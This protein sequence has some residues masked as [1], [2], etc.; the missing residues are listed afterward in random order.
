M[1]IEVVT[2]IAAEK[3]GRRCFM[4]E[5]SPEY[6]SV[7]LKRWANFTGKEPIKLN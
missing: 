3:L 2:M 7:I 6:T 5:I 4:M 1:Q